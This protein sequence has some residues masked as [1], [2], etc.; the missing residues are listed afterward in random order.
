MPQTES[1]EP[2]RK[3]GWN[4]AGHAWGM[5]MRGVSAKL[6]ARAAK[7]AKIRAKAMELAGS[8]GAELD[9][10]SGLDREYLLKAAGLLLRRA[11][12]AEDERN[13]I[14]TARNLI[15]DVERRVGRHEVQ[16]SV[17]AQLEQP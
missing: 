11:R 15:G 2:S 5:T 1:Q 3:R 6:Q 4:N 8:L 13:A 12:T 9:R 14:K 10:M 7:E 16:P 17:L